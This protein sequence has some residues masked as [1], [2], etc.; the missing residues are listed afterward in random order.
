MLYDLIDPL[1]MRCSTFTLH[2]CTTT[3]RRLRSRLM[4]VRVPPHAS[5]RPFLNS[6]RESRFPP[7]VGAHQHTECLCYSS[8]IIIII[9]IAL[10]T[11]PP[12]QVV[13]TSCAYTHQANTLLLHVYMYTATL[14][15]AD[16]LVERYSQSILRDTYY[17]LVVYSFF[18]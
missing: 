7:T 15:R 14:M 13:G 8:T 11:M 6:R 10:A 1:A 3:T 4:Y 17:P 18:R 5:I 9:I 16:S 12:Y 2:F